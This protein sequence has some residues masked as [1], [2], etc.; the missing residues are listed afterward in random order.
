MNKQKIKKII[1]GSLKIIFADA[2][3]TWERIVCIL[4]ALF[5]LW[6]EITFVRFFIFYAFGIVGYVV[7]DGFKY[8]LEILTSNKEVISNLTLILVMFITV[9][10]LPLFKPKV[11]K[12]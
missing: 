9:F 8:S 1:S 2:T 12:K 5:W 11:I 6:L 10:R 3:L 4:S 7:G